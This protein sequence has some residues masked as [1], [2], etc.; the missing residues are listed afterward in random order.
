MNPF[1]GQIM[2][3]GFGFAPRGWA[4]CDGQLLAINS[5]TALFSLLGTTFGGDGRTTFQLPDLRGR[6]IVHAGQGPGLDNIRQGQ[7]GGAYTITLQTAHLPAHA[8]TGSMKLGGS[9]EE[10]GAGHFIGANQA[11][12]TEDPG[13]G[14]VNA[15][16][17]TTNNTGG[18][19]A[20]NSR[21]PYLG[22]YY[23]IALEGVYPSRS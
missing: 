12:Y 23:C 19:Q 22:I 17:V 5:N 8:H 14:A 21:N 4:F 9:P 15:G 2:A 20:F 10:A 7:S 6:S 11:I 18:G 16:A 13:S 1:L 3:V